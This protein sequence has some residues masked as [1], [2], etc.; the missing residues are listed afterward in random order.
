MSGC[1]DTNPCAPVNPCDCVE[2]AAIREQGPPGPG[3]APGGIPVFQIGAVVAGAT[4]QV[5]IVQVNPLLYTLNFVIPSANVNTPNIWTEVQTFQGTA[6]F[7][8]GFNASGNSTIENLTVQKL[9]V[10]DAGTFIGTQTFTAGAIFNDGIAV[11]GGV[12]ADNVSVSGTLQ[13]AGIIALPPNVPILGTTVVDNCGNFY[14]VGN[15]GPNSVSGSTGLAVNVP[16]NQAETAL[17]FSLPFT[18]P[19]VAGCGVP[20]PAVVIIRGDIVANAGGALPIDISTF[21]L[22]VRLDNAVTGTIL[23]QRTFTNFEAGGTWIVNALIPPG[24]HTLWFTIAGL[25]VG[26]STI[27]LIA[28]DCSVDF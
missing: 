1:G 4:P 10:A 25:S 15:I 8:N 6:I 18:V 21:R 11:T 16:F 9:T 2:P 7:S 12:V 3:G 22:F 17:P 13:N 5:T 20:Q 24:S 27:T 26:T 23:A 14:F 19:N 28:I